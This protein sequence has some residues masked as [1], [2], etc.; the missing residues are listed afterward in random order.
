MEQEL[1]YELK[2]IKEIIN[3]QIWNVASNS[4]SDIKM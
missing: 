4:P 2:L 1:Q 3:N